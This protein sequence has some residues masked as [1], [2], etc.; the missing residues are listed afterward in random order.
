MDK[1]LQKQLIIG[2]TVA[3]LLYFGVLNPLLKWLGIKDD[4]DST[5][6]N[7]AASNPQSFWSPLFWKNQRSPI[8]LTAASAEGIAR[9]IY[10]SFGVFNDYEEQAIGALKSL[11]YQTQ[12]SYLAEVFFKLYSMDLITFLRGGSWP[13]DRL[14]DSDVADLNSYLSKLPVS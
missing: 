12:V 9:T 2:G 6:L 7:N 1:T 5:T 8:I 4:Q 10:D 11:H 13:Q 3:G 14:S